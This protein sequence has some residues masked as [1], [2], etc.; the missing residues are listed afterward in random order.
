MYYLPQF[1][2]LVYGDSATLS[3]VGLLPL[4]LGVSVGNPVA[5]VITSKKGV[6]LA[7]A[8]GGAALQ[9]LATGLMTR[10]TSHTSRAEAVIILIILGFG[11]GTVMSG[12]LLSAQV[13]VPE[14]QIGVVTGL[15]I[16][17]FTL[18][19]IFGVA[20]FATV[21]VNKLSTYLSQLGLRAAQVQAILAD[22]KNVRTEFDS[23]MTTK[24]VEIYTKSLQNGW[25]LMFGCACGLLIS[26]ALSKQHA[27]RSS[28]GTSGMQNSK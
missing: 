25:W 6:S 11:Q 2:Q 13:A 10:W 7:N 8:I 3:G 4:M 27:F 26:A 22:V 9:V 24:I 17:L 28:T 19:Q 21:Y 16:F 12:L 18:G 23:E 15:T 20:L 1:F 5:A 14:V